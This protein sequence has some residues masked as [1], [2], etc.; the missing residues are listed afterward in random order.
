MFPAHQGDRPGP[1]LGLA[2]DV[3]AGFEAEQD[4]E[5]AADQGLV[6]DDRHPDH[7]PSWVS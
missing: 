4:R 3:E 2:D 1:V 5:A 7:G 6:I